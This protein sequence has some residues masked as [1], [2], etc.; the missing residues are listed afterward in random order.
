MVDNGARNVVLASQHPD[1]LAG[2]FDLISQMGAVL[3]VIPVDVTSKE[4]L[5][6]AYTE[7]K[8]S[9]PPI[10]GIIN[11]VMV[12]RDHPFL[13]TSWD[14]FEAVLAPKVARTCNLDEFF[15]ED[16]ALDFF[17]GLMSA[18]SIFGNIGQSAYSAANHYAAS[19]VR[20]QRARGLAGFVV[21]IGLLAGLGYIYL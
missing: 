2:V 5:R 19:L 14:D 20:R 6:A 7:I 10:G 11:G 4:G 17:I 15:G 18:T 21:V 13:H 12:L 3:R 1:V 16:E 9:M 8:S